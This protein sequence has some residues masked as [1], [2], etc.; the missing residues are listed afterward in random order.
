SMGIREG[1]TKSSSIWG[2]VGFDVG[3]TPK[4]LMGLD[5]I[6]A[7]GIRRLVS[8]GAGV[9]EDDATENVPRVMVMC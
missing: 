2:W 3:M 5:T 7:M 6:G 9:D 8:K 4:V 1:V